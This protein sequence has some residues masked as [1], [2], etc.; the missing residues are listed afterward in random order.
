[1]SSTLIRDDLPKAAA[2]SHFGRLA[3]T[4]SLPVTYLEISWLVTASMA[5]TSLCF[6][7]DFL[8][9]QPDAPGVLQFAAEPYDFF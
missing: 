6:A 7:F 4:P 1:M 2:S 5:L 9:G 3:M 8:L